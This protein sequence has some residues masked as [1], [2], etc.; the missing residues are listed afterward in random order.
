[1]LKM[2]KLEEEEIQVRHNTLPAEESKIDFVKSEVNTVKSEVVK[3]EVVVPSAAVRNEDVT[4]LIKESFQQAQSIEEHSNEVKLESQKSS[5]ASIAG[6]VKSVKTLGSEPSSNQLELQLSSKQIQKIPSGMEVKSIINSDRFKKQRRS[7]VIS[8]SFKLQQIDHKVDGH[9]QDIKSIF[10]VLDQVSVT[11]T[12]A[13]VQ[14]NKL[15]K[16]AN[17]LTENVRSHSDKITDINTSLSKVVEEI[18]L[19]D[20]RV[21]DAGLPW[22]LLTSVLR[23]FHDRTDTDRDLITKYSTD[24]KI[25]EF[26]SAVDTTHMKFVLLDDLEEKNEKKFNSFANDTD[27]RFASLDK[28]QKGI[29]DFIKNLQPILT[30][31]APAE[32]AEAIA[33]LTKL[34]LTESMRQLIPSRV[35][36][37]DQKTRKSGAG[38]MICDE[39]LEK[40]V[41]DILTPMLNEKDAAISET[42][43]KLAQMEGLIYDIRRDVGMLTDKLA[44][45]IEN[46]ESQIGENETEAEVEMKSVI[47]DLESK[48]NQMEY[49]LKRLLRSD[50]TE[51]QLSKINEMF[52]E[53]KINT[54]TKDEFVAGIGDK[55]DK[56]EIANII[57]REEYDSGVCSLNNSLNI[58]S[59]KIK[60]H[61]LIENRINLLVTETERKISRDELSIIKS[62]I[63]TEFG[64]LKNLMNMKEENDRKRKQKWAAIGTPVNCIS[65]KDTSYQKKIPYSHDDNDSSGVYAALELK[66]GMMVKPSMGPY[67]SYELDTLRKLSRKG[68]PIS[69]AIH[70]KEIHRRRLDLEEQA[71]TRRIRQKIERSCGGSHTVHSFPTFDDFTVTSGTDS[72]ACTNTPKHSSQGSR[73]T[74]A[75]SR[76]YPAS[77]T[78]QTASADELAIEEILLYSNNGTVYRGAK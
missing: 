6:S 43:E 35:D 51:T 47:E 66:E 75:T 11:A 65:C 33:N 64:T 17:V 27:E 31:I 62:E 37:H 76:K 70:N 45:I 19:I 41:T 57:Q 72:T 24:E 16:T 54:I 18:R 9:E 20:D 55:A 74:G 28:N 56:E 46:G 73:S 68:R 3:S 78:K 63:K 44:E 36:L 61:A 32:S 53:F 15:N 5:Q 12:S 30:S 67:R 71:K 50:T 58:L 14:S 52:E 25:S 77:K 21:T 23:F 49:D 2:M 34:A 42:N 38:G 1:M 48:F 40:K 39:E 60:E 8:D 29:R 4:E 7:S 10:D 26:V 22:D 13:D 59:Q 69:K